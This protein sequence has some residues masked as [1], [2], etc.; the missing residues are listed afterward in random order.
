[1]AP[2]C[3]GPTAPLGVPEHRRAGAVRQVV[4]PGATLR[5]ARELVAPVPHGRRVLGARRLQEDLPVRLRRRHPALRPGQVAQGAPDAGSEGVLRQRGRRAKGALSGPVAAGDAVQGERLGPALALLHELPRAGAAGGAGAGRLVHPA[6]A[7]VV[8]E[9][10]SV[11][12]GDV[13]VLLQELR[14]AVHGEAL[15]GA[16]R[17]GEH[18]AAAARGPS[19]AAVLH[20]E[21]LRRCAW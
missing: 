8:G 7:G 4:V 16:V 11:L 19:L 21:A 3:A 10:R 18:A 1:M 15:V 17:Q 5:A 13:R 14:G 6:G 2:L 20:E 12:A 9:I